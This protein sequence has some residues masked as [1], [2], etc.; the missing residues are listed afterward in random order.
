MKIRILLIMMTFILFKTIFCTQKY[1]KIV[2]E[3][4][5]FENNHRFFDESLVKYYWICSVSYLK[6]VY[7]KTKHSICKMLGIRHSC[8]YECFMQDFMLD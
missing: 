1:E 5:N 2:T 7:C 3:K 4:S 6:N 8:P